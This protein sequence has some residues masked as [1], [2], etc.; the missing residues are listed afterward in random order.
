ML[1]SFVR[2][3][4]P[5]IVGVIV[6][7]AARI[8]LDLDEGLVTAIVTATAGAAYHAAVRWIETRWPKAGVLLGY[9]RAPQYKKRDVD[10]AA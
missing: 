7:Q 2:T 10:L 1:P 9:A 6:G 8:G 4:V 3:L 5:I